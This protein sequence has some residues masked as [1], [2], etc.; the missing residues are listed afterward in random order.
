MLTRPL[1]WVLAFIASSLVAAEPPEVVNAGHGGHRS[2]EVLFVL[3]KDV[4]PTKP[5][6][7]IV[8]VGTNDI[9]N[10][11]KAVP[12]ETFHVNL[13]RIME[14]IRKVD[15]R[16]L[17]LTIPPCYEPYLLKRHPAAFFSPEG[18]NGRII[19]GNRVI[20]AVAGEYGIHVVDIHALYEREGKIGTDLES[21]LRNAANSGTSDG[22]HPTPK[23]YE[24]IAKLVYE[25]ID[26][27]QLPR[28]GIVCVGDSLT[29][30]AGVAGSGTS[31]GETYPAALKRFLAGAR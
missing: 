22:V 31:E 29:F 1:R 3:K 12:T 16:A 10:S 21:Y 20:N 25:A 9:I 30:G 18:P 5:Q 7:V 14:A 28:T 6:L 24:A 15:A 23:G 11:K 19:E 8:M 4:L 13:Q 27:N 17:L 2:A 26:A